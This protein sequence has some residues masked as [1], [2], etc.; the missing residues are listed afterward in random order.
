MRSNYI[1]AFIDNH[2]ETR[3]RFIFVLVREIIAILAILALSVALNISGFNAD[4]QKIKD[5]DAAD[6]WKTSVP[7][8][9]GLDGKLVEDAASLVGKTD[10][11][12]F[13]V[14]Y[15]GK[16]VFEKY[17]RE[18][19]R[20]TSFKAFSVTKSVI[21]A[22]VGIAIDKG[23]IHSVDDRV[24]DYL[25]D[26]FSNIDDPDKNKITIRQ[27][28]TMTP[29]FIE[30]MSEWT[31]GKDWVESALQLPLKYK[32]GTHFQ[33]SN[34]AVHMLS[35][36]LTNATGISTYDFANE[37]L[38]GPMSIKPYAWP[39]D[40]QGIYYGHTDIMLRPRDMAKLGQL[41]LNEGV[42]RNKRFL[43]ADW[44]AKSTSKQVSTYSSQANDPG[45]GYGFCW[46]V[47]TLEGR[48]VYTAVGSYGQYICV[49]PSLD[50]VYVM[51]GK[52]NSPRPLTE[53]M[54]MIMMRECLFPAVPG[55]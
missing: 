39:M 26:Y 46:W 8:A 9:E 22:L 6:G 50:M 34:S 40:P 19:D 23:Y 3:G 45:N 17:S 28:L 43:S 29:G 38:F 27:L 4:I 37:Y 15:R 20:F 2:F 21:S 35:A 51:T 7:A 24:A 47:S 53:D 55:K 49:I 52:P 5:I 33:F 44:V 30:D 16:I 31:A 36:I 12:S 13:L 42:W 11:E 54:R 1:K 32:P 10:T 25:P 14:V 18:F 41:Y 48:H